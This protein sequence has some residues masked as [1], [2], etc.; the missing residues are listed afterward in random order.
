MET[1]GTLTIGLEIHAALKTETKMFCGCLNNPNERKANKNICP[2]CVG[3]PGTLP[4]I[5]KKA[6]EFV[7]K[8]GMALKGT[9]F[10]KNRSK[11]DRKNYFYPDLPKGY[12]IS[13]YDEPFV[14][15]GI[16]HNIRIRRI[17]LEEDAGSLTHEGPSAG[18][19]QSASLV[20]FNRASTPLIELVTEPDIKSADQA[21]AFAQEFQ[22]IVRYLHISDA[23]M[24][25]GLLRLEAN[26]SIN[27]GP[28]LNVPNGTKVEV[29][30]INSF[31]AL[32]DAIEYEYK[33]QTKLFAEG[34]KIIQETRGWN[35]L[36]GETV[37]QRIKEEAH[38]YRYFPEPDLPPMDATAFDLAR[39]K[40]EIPELPE[41]KRK[42]FMQEFNLGKTEAD[43]LVQNRQA[44]EFFENAVSE[45]TTS[46]P[47]S[48]TPVNPLPLVYNYFTSDL[49]GLM[50]KAD[51]SFNDLRI[52]PGSFARL[53][54]LIAH[55][56]VS[57]RSAKDILALMVKTGADPETIMKERGLEQTA[58]AGNVEEI[59]E[60]IIEE[61]P[62]A[63]ADYK[64]GKIASLQFLIGKA[65]GRL[66]GA[67]NPKILKEVF[68]KLLS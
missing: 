55:N 53:V 8:L 30:N 46:I 59:A 18:S 25:K 29:K 42:R 64:K 5:N 40:Q 11:F 7:L 21:V 12:Q 28:V 32:H 9:L 35:A 17:H 66:K 62:R 6:V 24:E 68:E 23:D 52:T 34:K 37:S 49:W 50:K 54:T 44:A 67:A 63:V 13:Q 3:H 38:D 48:S 57:S 58:H 65:M 16:L 43:I 47:Q 1:D 10:P 51:I 41:A 19:E 31:K 61:H 4:T 22:R 26:I 14:E 15:G 33:R 60:K 36:K 45:I 20:D 39:M 27:R 2:V 56:I